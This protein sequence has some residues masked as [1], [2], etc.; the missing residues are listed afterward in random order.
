MKH[1]RRTGLSL[2]DLHDLLLT[3]RQ[4]VA[5]HCGYPLDSTFIRSILLVPVIPLWRVA[6]KSHLPV[7]LVL[8]T[9]QTD[10][11]TPFHWASGTHLTFD[12]SLLVLGDHF[13][14]LYLSR[15]FL[16]PLASA[17]NN[18]SF[19]LLIK[20]TRLVLLFQWFLSIHFHFLKYN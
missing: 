13:P 11:N 12:F 18:L 9:A 4:S 5:S 19:Q 15:H 3:V 10:G 6:A 20:R 1:T 7:L 8:C 2:W 16:C 14:C 17:D